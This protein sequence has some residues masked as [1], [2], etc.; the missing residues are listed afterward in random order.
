[1]VLDD[2]RGMPQREVGGHLLNLATI[3]IED[4]GDRLIGPVLSHAIEAQRAALQRVMAPSE[5]GV[6]SSMNALV[7]RVTRITLSGGRLFIAAALHRALGIT[8]WTRSA[9]GPAPF[10]HWIVTLGIIEQIL[11]DDLFWLDSGPAIPG[12]QAP[13]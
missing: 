13:L 1:M 9:F 12:F 4:L 6:R 5:E 3:Q 10:V 2:K 8:Q 11:Y 7:A